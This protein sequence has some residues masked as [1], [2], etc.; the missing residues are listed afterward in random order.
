[1]MMWDNPVIIVSTN[2]ASLKSVG[3]VPIGLTS[4]VLGSLPLS[5][6]PDGRIVL[7]AVPRLAPTVDYEPIVKNKRELIAELN[8][9]GIRYC[10]ADSPR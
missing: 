9:L 6:W 1:M 3:A 7:I 2:G 10:I 8:T 5:A 4:N